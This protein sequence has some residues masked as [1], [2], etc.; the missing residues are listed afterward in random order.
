MHMQRIFVKQATLIHPGKPELSRQ[1]LDLILSEGCIVDIAGSLKIPD[2]SLVIEGKNLA[3]A[4]GL[5]ELHSTI[6]EPGNEEHE[7][8]NQTLNSAAAGGFTALLGMPL[9]KPKADSKS[10][11]EYLLRKSQGSATALYPVGHITQGAEGEELSEMYDMQSTGVQV[12]SD[13]KNLISNTKLLALALQYSSNLNVTL[14]LF[15]S[16]KYLAHNAFAF[17]SARTTSLGLKSMPLI[18]EALAVERILSLMRYYGGKVHFN[19]ICT[20]KGAELIAEAKK[21]GLEVSCD[22]NFHHLIFSDESY[23]DFDTR[24]KVM[25]PLVN[26]EE[27]AQLLHHL[28]EGSIEAIAVDHIARNIEY[29]KCEFQ[30]AAFGMMG[31][32]NAFSALRYHLDVPAEKLIEWMSINPRKILNWHQPTIEKGSRAEL[33]VFEKDETYT[34]TKKMRKSGA[35]N[36]PFID[37]TLKSKILLTVNGENFW[38][39]KE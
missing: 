12:F 26:R 6:H 10:L 25:P 37:K 18:T 35:E 24:F 9:T 38:E 27:Q 11:V 36:S 2:D 33:F 7:T 31:L 3:I 1:K 5:M 17:E 15:A 13:Y 14:S 4:P 23:Y 20:G 29:K 39:N 19:S 21:E 30:N 22:V 8:L 32:E 28:M 34:Y 16:D